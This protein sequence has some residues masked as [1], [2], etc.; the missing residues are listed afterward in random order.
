LPALIELQ[1]VSKAFGSV[2]AIQDVSLRVEDGEALGIVGPNGAGK[3][4]LLNL[5]GGSLRPDGGRIL[6]ESRDI[7]R[8]S[9]HRRC[10]AG[11]ART[12]QIPRPFGGLTAYE[13]VLVGSAHGRANGAGGAQAA[14]VS[15]LE[16]VGLLHKAN[17]LAGS[18]T[19]LERKRLEL[20]RAIV[21]NPRVLLLDEIAGGLTEPEVNELVETVQELRAQGVSI[22]WIEHIVQALLSV[23]GRLVA[24]ASG[25]KLIE[26]EPDAVIASAELRDIYLGSE[27]EGH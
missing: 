22:V 25:R 19:L 13:N 11:I 18:L 15:A 27:L 17:V 1:G 23:V 26:G 12:F 4:T 3:T 9:G 2:R 8:L 20:A 7:T 16:Q 5:I 10:R 14:C 21:T 6:F 24:L